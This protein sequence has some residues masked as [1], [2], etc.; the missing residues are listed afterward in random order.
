MRSVSSLQTG[1]P[2]PGQTA[3]V[4]ACPQQPVFS[5]QARRSRGPAAGWGTSVARGARRGETRTDRVTTGQ[6]PAWLGPRTPRRAVSPGAARGPRCLHLLRPHRTFHQEARN[7]RFEKL[8]PS[9]GTA[10]GGSR[11]CSPPL[12]TGP[13]GFCGR[14]PPG[15]RQGG[16]G[17]P[18]SGSGTALPCASVWPRESHCHSKT[19]LCLMENGGL[20]CALPL[21]RWRLGPQEGRPQYSGEGPV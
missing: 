2:T 12:L 16:V 18:S 19:L 4:S 14:E 13:G 17:G 20:S 5:C 3:A 6:P 1:A 7:L 9:A 10:P 15:G 8:L 11:G 21:P